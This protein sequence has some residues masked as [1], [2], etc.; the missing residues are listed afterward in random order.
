[1][2]NKELLYCNADPAIWADRPSFTDKKNN[3]WAS[4][5]ITLQSERTSSRWN[6]Q[7]NKQNS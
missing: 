1:L 3:G 5:Q 4:L 6:K 7:T 2:A